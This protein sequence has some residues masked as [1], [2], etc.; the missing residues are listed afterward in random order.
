[1][2]RTPLLT[3]LL[4]TSLGAAALIGCDNEEPSIAESGPA[5]VLPAFLNF[6]VDCGKTPASQRFQVINSGNEELNV[7]SAMATG[8]FVIVAELPMT[9]Q[10]GAA[11][12]IEVKPPAAV[13][14]TDLGGTTKIGRLTVV[15][16]DP[17]GNAAIELRAQIRGANLALTDADGAPITRVDMASST[18]ACPAPAAVFVRNTGNVAA[19]IKV[20]ES[21]YAVESSDSSDVAAGMSSAFQI[22]P[23]GTSDCATS[24][25]VNFEMITTSVCTV[26]PLVLQVTQTTNGSSDACFCGSTSGV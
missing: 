8:G 9:V 12:V 23:D 19:N 18:A 15:T 2:N 26:Q 14:G 17:N 5:A 21:D 7:T 20:G 10:P 13:I 4:W 6:P 22:I 3:S 16:N 25:Q 11:I 1:M 24:G